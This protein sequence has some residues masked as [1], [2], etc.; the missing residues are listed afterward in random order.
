M[1]EEMG[2]GLDSTINEGGSNISQG[3]KQL[4]CLARAML[5]SNRIMIIDE[6]TANV[7]PV[8]VITSALVKKKIVGVLWP[9]GGRQ[10]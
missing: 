8:L 6:A 10:D 5:M 9:S 7:D 3:Q 4:F 2:D 1:V